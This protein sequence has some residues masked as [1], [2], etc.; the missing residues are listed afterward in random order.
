MQDTVVEDSGNYECMGRN[1]WGT[2]YSRAVRVYIRGM[3]SRHYN[4]FSFLQPS[5]FSEDIMTVL[6]TIRGL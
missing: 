2:V 3:Y 5:Q 4:L 1:E 6:Q